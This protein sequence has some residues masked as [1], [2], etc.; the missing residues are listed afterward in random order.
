VTERGAA[1]P[2]QLLAGSENPDPRA[3]Y[4]P[5]TEITRKDS[6]QELHRFSIKAFRR[7]R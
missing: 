4:S 6:E 5:L 7:V 2:P 1:L 3:A